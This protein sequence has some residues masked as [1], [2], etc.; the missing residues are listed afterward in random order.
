MRNTG[1][2]KCTSDTSPFWIR[3]T[4]LTLCGGG[5]AGIAST[6]IKLDGG[7]GRGLAWPLGYEPDVDQRV[8]ARAQACCAAVP[9]A[10]CGRS[11]EGDSK[12]AAS[13]PVRGANR[14]ATGRVDGI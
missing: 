14:G 6:A 10:I 4:V 9:R 5:G 8:D 7:T 3:I 2:A 1:V 13:R 11:P 12:S